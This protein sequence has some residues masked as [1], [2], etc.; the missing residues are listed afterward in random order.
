MNQGNSM[1]GMM[2]D[3]HGQPPMQP[4]SSLPQYMQSQPYFMYGQVRLKHIN[5]L[6]IC[7]NSMLNKYN[8]ID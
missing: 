4:I 5:N 1:E 7:V 2:N 8:R 6:Y 3:S